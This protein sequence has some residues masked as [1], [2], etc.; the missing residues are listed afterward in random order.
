MDSDVIID[1]LKLALARLQ[2]N[3]A[4]PLQMIDFEKDDDT[5]HHVEFVTAA[6]NLRAENYDIPQ[7]DAMKTKQIAGRIIP[8]LATT[9][10]V[11]SGLVAIE[12]YKVIEA[13]GGIS[14]APLERF[15]NGFL[16]LAGPFYSNFKY[17][18]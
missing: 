2:L 1:G 3:D 12:L 5:N 13:N 4:K 15:K 7:A 14:K 11:V 8:A 9:T 17:L 18:I 6:S 10:A 16:N